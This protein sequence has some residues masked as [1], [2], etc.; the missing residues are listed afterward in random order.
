VSRVSTRTRRLVVS[1]VVLLL[2]GVVGYAAYR[3]SRPA[4]ARALGLPVVVGDRVY[5]TDGSVA[6]LDVDSGSRIAQV[7]VV[8]GGIA[9]STIAESGSDGD[10]IWFRAPSGHLDLL[11][12]A[13]NLPF[14]VT[15]D[16]GTLISA[17]VHPADPVGRFA[18]A[19]ELARVSAFDLA[20]AGLRSTTMFDGANVI[21]AAGDWVVLRRFTTAADSPSELWNT[22][23]GRA[24]LISRGDAAPLAVT[25]TG[26]VLRRRTGPGRTI[27]YD[28]VTPADPVPAADP[29]YCA[30]LDVFD[31]RLSPDAR[32]L[33]AVTEDNAYIV[34]VD[35]LRHGR[36]TAVTVHPDLGLTGITRWASNDSIITPE[37]RRFERCDLSGKCVVHDVSGTGR[38]A[39]ADPPG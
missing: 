30:T 31:A 14:T 27:C 1:A 7:V 26:A 6:D 39:A 21:D 36:W 2:A 22:R 8:P 5:L 15:P 33:L 25:A 12:V 20:T 23:T 37:D 4:D 3:R 32:H 19:A 35:D 9:Y 10:R 16:G 38:L 24:T 34:D 29:G 18:T 13:A 17:G 28:F 11:G